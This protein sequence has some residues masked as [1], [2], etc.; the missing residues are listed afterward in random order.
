MSGRR[1]VR[2]TFNNNNNHNRTRSR[3]NNVKASMKRNTRRIRNQ[4]ANIQLDKYKKENEF[5]NEFY[6]SQ[7]SVMQQWYHTIRGGQ[8]LKAI[9]IARKELRKGKSLSG[10]DLNK[11]LNINR[12]DL[13]HHLKVLSDNSLIFL[14]AN[15]SAVSSILVFGLFIFTN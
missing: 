1:G 7:Q 8:A 5:L 13:Y 11:I 4:Q 6:E 3:R 2:R 9:L 14:D 15:I 12:Y 10:S